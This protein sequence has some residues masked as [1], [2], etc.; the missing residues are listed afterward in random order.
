MRDH[1]MLKDLE[2]DLRKHCLA[3]VDSVVARYNLAEKKLQDILK[4]LGEVD[5]DACCYSVL[6]SSWI[7][8]HLH[9]LL[10]LFAKSEQKTVDSTNPETLRRDSGQ[11]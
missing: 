10:C 11:T 9:L 4:T 3:V 6:V 2:V 8:R 5:V 1:A 7:G